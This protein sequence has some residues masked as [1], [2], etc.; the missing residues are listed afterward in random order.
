MAAAPRF[1]HLRTHT[2]YSLLEGAVPVKKLVGLCD[3]MSMPAIAV[4][5]TNNM[6]AALEF[7]TLAK[8]AGVQPIRAAHELARYLE[9]FPCGETF[10]LQ[11]MV[12]VEG[13]AGVFYI[14]TPG[15][16]RG[17]VMTET[18]LSSNTNK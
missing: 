1:I 9:D 10:L 16:S 14:R 11:R 15:A 18:G 5:D 17:R 2:E 13:E 4:T 8:G 12:D 7:S 6:F 3:K